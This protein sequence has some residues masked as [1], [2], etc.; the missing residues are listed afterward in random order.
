M[1]DFLQSSESPEAYLTKLH[2]DCQKYGGYNLL[3]GDSTQVW[4]H[5]NRNP[6]MTGPVKL[7]C[8][9]VCWLWK[10]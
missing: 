3:I 10:C 2:A 8:N 1:R 5:T 6:E 7:P 4:Y 9:E